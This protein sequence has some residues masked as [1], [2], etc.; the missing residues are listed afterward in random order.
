MLC[1]PRARAVPAKWLLV[2]AAVAAC[3]AAGCAG[4][5][6]PVSSPPPPQPVTVSVSPSSA[7]VFLGATQQFT[8][9]VQNAANQAVTW[10]V[11]GFAGGNSTV[12]TIN[13]N[14]LY[15]APAVLPTPAGVTITAQSQAS[16]AASGSAEVTVRSDVQ[17]SVAPTA[18]D[19]ELGAAVQLT[20]SVSG[21]GSPDLG[22]NWSV[23]G[24]PGGDAVVGTVNTSGLY[25]APQVL[26][27][28]A[29]AVRAT[30]VADAAK[31]AE[32]AV[33]VTSNL[34]IAITAGPAEV[35]NGAT[36]QY[37]AAV[38]PAP[39]S[40]PSLVI[41]WSVSGSGC[42]GE[43]CGTID[44]EGLFRAPVVAPEPPVVL[45][46]A[47]S[48]ADPSKTA[49][50]EVTIRSVFTVN[51]SPTAAT[52]ALEDSLQF[53]AT[54]GGTTDQRI[55]WDVEGIVGGNEMFGHITNTPTD[56][57]RYTAPVNM[58][59]AGEVTVR[60]VSQF[61]PSLSA[62]AVVTL[63]SHIEVIVTPVSSTRSVGQ[64][65]RLSAAVN[66]SNPAV[67]WQVNGIVGGNSAVGR[68]CIADLVPCQPIS[69]GSPV[70]YLA[71]NLVPSPPQVTIEAISQAHTERRGTAVITII[72]GITVSVTPSAITIPA[73][74]TQQF[75]AMV[76]GTA[77]QNVSW[78]VS[79][80]GCNGD[81]CGTISSAGLYTAPE[82]V[83]S[84]NTVTVR[85]TSAE[86]ATKSGTATVTISS[87]PFIRT[88]RPSSLTAG[89]TGGILLRVVGNNFVAG[90]GSAATTIVFGGADKPT[91]CPG[92]TECTTLLTTEDLAD[93]GDRAVTVRHPDGTVSDPVTF[94][95]AA[96]ETTEAAIPLEPGNSGAGGVDVAVVDFSTLGSGAEPLNVQILGLITNGACHAGAVPVRLVRPAEGE[97]Q[98]ELC[99][100]G[101]GIHPANVFRFSGPEPNDL[102][103]AGVDSPFG[104]LVIRLTVRVP[105]TAAPGPRTLWIQNDK[106]D[107]TAVAGGIEVQ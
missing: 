18:A 96:D 61:D 87:G 8:A 77:N 80:S 53:T 30:S 37:Q 84:P 74:S 51:L 31:H 44:T 2:C 63:I 83:P 90:S 95:V 16:P 40:N 104:G 59:A 19:V 28:A 100:G 89:A 52:V 94:V 21:S 65:Q 76:E 5:T 56:A 25:L 17:V 82:A 67:E 54:V 27:T 88:L 103:I 12:G 14:G 92:A 3:L 43:A 55:I 34:T 97:A 105:A 91:D 49:V 81:A 72:P 26:P 102:V 75:S 57:G 47:A 50:R 78:S 60:A 58:P 73:G 24:I 62:S 6:A 93:A 39:G 36:A 46:T 15:T 66:S 99:I 29:V 101:P 20:A 33:T 68:I 38:T 11:S 45:V 85:A 106:K 13:S 23:N 86:D 69:T 64:R 10:Q 32:A 9:T 70:D 98:R 79:G 1:F 48:A 4:A 7:E 42:S 41:H 22:V 107:R 35:N 71:P